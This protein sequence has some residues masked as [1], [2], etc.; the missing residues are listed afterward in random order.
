MLKFLLLVP[1]LFFL[2]NSEVISKRKT[3]PI[4][5]QTCPCWWDLE[6]ALIDPQTGEPFKCACCRRGGRQ[7]GYPMHEWCTKDKKTRRG[8]IGTSN[9]QFTLSELGHPCHF[10]K[11]RRDCAWCVAK[12]YQCA[13]PNFALPK[14]KEHGQYCQA[15]RRNHK[16]CGGESLDCM[17]RPDICA[18]N[19]S[20]MET[21]QKVTK[22]WYYHQCVCNAGFIGNGITCVEATNVANASLPGRIVVNLDSSLTKDK[23]FEPSLEPNFD[24]GLAEDLFQVIN[25]LEGDCATESC[26]ASIMKCGLSQS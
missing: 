1:V 14:G 23:L 22:D 10:D 13:P 4:S 18:P 20:C 17:L 24:Q 15:F 16:D 7:C 9:W 2:S 3:V 6:G 21:H 26:D 5:K 19:A 11:S 12:G 8:C 25:N